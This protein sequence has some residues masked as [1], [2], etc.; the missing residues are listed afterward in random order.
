MDVLW[1]EASIIRK[2]T[3]FD[4]A[5]ST[6]VSI[7]D[8]LHHALAQRA[9]IERTSVDDIAQRFLSD[10]IAAV[11]QSMAQA[12]VRRFQALRRLIG[13]GKDW[14]PERDAAAELIAEREQVQR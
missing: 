7:P 6:Y 3:S 2:P 1:L 12:S 4:G 11:D 8:D 9:S 10:A 13:M 5:M 14:S